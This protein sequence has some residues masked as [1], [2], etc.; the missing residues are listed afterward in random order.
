MKQSSFLRN[1]LIILLFL[2]ISGKLY[3]GYYDEGCK[4]FSNKKYE[5]A[6]EMFLKS[7]EV[8][9]DGNSYYFM[10]E[11]E[12]N[13][14]NYDKAEE[15]YKI[16]VTKNMTGKYKKLAYW[17]IIVFEEQKG[18]YNEMVIACREYWDA[19]KDESAK[20]KVETLINKFL[21]TDN[22]EAK[23]LY[24]NGVEF[25][26]KNIPD[27]AKEAFYNALRI[28]SNFL[29]PKF[30][31]GLI[32]FNENNSSQAISYFNDIIEKIPFYGDVH[33]LLGDIYFNKQS[34]KNSIEHLQKAKEYGFLDSKT[35]YS[36]ILKAG[37]SYY[38]LGEL[39]KAQEEYLIA[40]DLNKKESEP[41]LMLSAIYIKKNNFDQAIPVLLK[42]KE[43]NPNNP[44]ILFQIGSIYYKMNDLK[45]TQYFQLLFNKYYPPKEPI[46]QKYFKAFS[47][48]L[49][50]YYDNKK[51]EDAAK[52]IETL[53]ESQKNNETNLMA[54][55]IYYNI[56]K[57]DKAVDYF[58]KLP[59]TN[60]D[61]YLLCISYARTNKENKAKDLLINLLSLNG[62]LEKAKSESAIKKIV[63][64]IENEKLK[65]EE[66]IK[67]A[68][69]EE[70]K[71]K[72]EEEKL[73]EERR[74]NEKL[75]S[76]QESFKNIKEEKID[77]PSSTPK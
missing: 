27:K 36:I 76:E 56:G 1:I 34:Y 66:E 7:I 69:A 41:L 15:Y 47:L 13:E 35:K 52:I 61:K 14:G 49:K 29:A 45:Y 54:A 63:N 33:L 2:F 24:N 43:L 72:I 73:K 28:D 70:E 39:E 44:E 67:K 23:L 3:A 20:K 17:N 77:I 71:K 59:L 31:M 62:Y 57:H 53:P 40:A 10:G 18:K 60:D 42:A 21:W 37:V 65:R 16:S 46:P 5:K 75:M 22:D 6:R 19:M 68:A 74:K 58:E 8:S 9:D 64:E 4:Y 48:L 12:K 51:Y 30:E 11:M 32:L 26:K 55:K 25:K 38:E 50:N